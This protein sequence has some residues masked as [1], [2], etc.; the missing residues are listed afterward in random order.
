MAT[1][2]L[3]GQFEVPIQAGKE[4]FLSFKTSTSA[5]TPTPLPSQ[6][7]PPSLQ[8]IKR[9]GSKVDLSPRLHLVPRIRMSGAMHLLIT[10]RLQGRPKSRWNDNVKQD[11]CKMKIK[12]WTVCVQDRGKWRD[13][14]EKAKSFNT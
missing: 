9:P 5:L 11:I 1:K 8:G 13:V 12:N 3:A 2:L 4:I 6:R 14:I 7:L 10:T